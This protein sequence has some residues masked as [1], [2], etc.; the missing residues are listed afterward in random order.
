MSYFTVLEL[1]PYTS[2]MM[3]IAGLGTSTLIAWV[4]L[5][6]C[7]ALPSPQESHFHLFAQADVTTQASRAEVAS[8]I[9]SAGYYT[10]WVSDWFPPETI[11]WPL[12]DLILY[13]FLVLDSSSNLTCG[14]DTNCALLRRLIA[15]GHAHN[16][17]VGMSIGGWS[18]SQYFSTALLTENSRKALAQQ[19]CVLVQTLGVDVVDIDWEYPGRAGR[20]SDFLPQDSQ[21]LLLFLRELGSCLPANVLRT[22][23]VSTIPFTGPDGALMKDL[24]P[25]AQELD[26]ASIMA[27]DVFAPS[28]HPGPNAPLYDGCGNSSQ[29]LAS[30]AGGYSSWTSAG[31][32]PGQLMLALAPY[33]TL[34]NSED[35]SLQTRAD[36]ANPDNGYKVLPDSNNQIYFRTLL[37]SGA[38][39]KT[40][41]GFTG[42][43]GFD[44]HFDKCSKT[45]YLVSKHAHQV[46]SFDDPNSIARKTVFIGATGMKGFIFW[47]ISGDTDQGDL[48]Q[49]AHKVMD[50]FDTS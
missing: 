28:S 29:R 13:A 17:L 16:V 19:I 5:V 10:N 40:D 2:W 38:L 1:H 32:P 41:K 3:K 37:S 4:V 22:A 20:T 18:D 9:R 30:A 45:P 14:E 7:T 47:D 43:S 49:A 39:T 26:F 6:R 33:G 12:Y 23:A 11:L 50:A 35:D 21:D 34:S 27:Y 25:F 24:S 42:A 44:R 31:F 36:D 8:K 46:V 15:A 48:V